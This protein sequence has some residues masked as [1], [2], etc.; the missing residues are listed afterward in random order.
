MPRAGAPS[1][2]LP[3]QVY[4]FS[5][6]AFGEAKLARQTAHLPSCPFPS[7]VVTDSMRYGRESTFHPR[8]A[9]YIFWKADRAVRSSGPFGCSFGCSAGLLGSEEH[10]LNRASREVSNS[11]ENTCTFRWLKRAVFMSILPVITVDDCLG[12]GHILSDRLPNVSNARRPSPRQIATGSSFLHR[13][14][15]APGTDA[16]CA[17]QMVQRRDSRASVS[18]L[19]R[20]DQGI[21][22]VARDRRVSR[23]ESDM[24]APWPLARCHRARIH[25][26]RQKVSRSGVAA[27]N[28]SRKGHIGNRKH[29]RANGRAH[30]SVCAKI[31]NT[32]ESSGSP[33]LG[34]LSIDQWRKFHLV[35]GQH[36]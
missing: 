34:P 6:W 1:A 36:H 5:A 4:V 30:D 2:V 25:A 18:D 10:A 17:G 23:L 20:N 32:L 7:L 35:H 8:A 29:H 19:H 9:T 16:K 33:I 24:D 27:R 26:M 12:C 28:L 31:R 21:L 13:G 15:F 3:D 14:S 22:P 11:V